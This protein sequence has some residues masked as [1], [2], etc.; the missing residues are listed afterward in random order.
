MY[1]QKGWCRYISE[2]H[3]VLLVLMGLLLSISY[4]F[5]MNYHPREREW[6]FGGSSEDE[7]VD[8]GGYSF[9]A[10]P[11]RSQVPKGGAYGSS[12]NDRKAEREAHKA[13]RVDSLADTRFLDVEE[14]SL[15]PGQTKTI[16]VSLTPLERVP[17]Y[18]TASILCGTSST[19]QRSSL[20]DSRTGA[21][22]VT[23]SVNMIATR[24]R[25]NACLQPRVYRLLFHFSEHEAED[26]LTQTRSQA[27]RLVHPRAGEGNQDF[28]SLS[29]GPANDPSICIP[30]VLRARV[31]TSLLSVSPEVVPFGECQIGEYKSAH[32]TITNLSDLPAV[33]T[34]QLT[35]KTLSCRTSTLS[36]PPHSSAD[37]KL[38]YAIPL[39]F[40]HP[41][42]LTHCIRSF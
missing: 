27:M 7:E 2:S 42:Y 25:E 15:P 29:L 30:V 12:R 5:C 38:E 19:T 35:S 1:V 23:S 26:P 41:K 31:C 8:G 14:L 39:N 22:H 16:Y 9:T 11:L 33:A 6:P 17:E 18:Y 34:Q 10:Q 13:S 40:F 24:Q 20:T 32:V 4:E 36:I 28:H 21:E 37:L 3:N